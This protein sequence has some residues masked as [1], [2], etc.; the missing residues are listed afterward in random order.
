MANYEQGLPI[1]INN[2]GGYVNDSTDKGK[3][4]YQGISRANWPNWE[5]WV[6]IDRIK[7]QRKIAFNEIILNLWPLVKRFYK[8]NFWD[9]NKLDQINNQ[10]IANEIFD[11]GVN[12][13]IS[14]GV[15][16][17][18]EALNLLNKNQKEYN[19]IAEDG[20]IGTITINLTNN[21][22]NQIALLKTINGLQFMKYVE[23]CDRDKSQEKFFYGWLNRT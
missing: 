21:H 17:L 16:F 20:I 18:Q 4:T 6:E 14:K 23:I 8:L 2:E 1:V 5:G 7:Q 9:T 22:K 13:G 19:D 11:T 10:Q 15:K 12:M 3:E